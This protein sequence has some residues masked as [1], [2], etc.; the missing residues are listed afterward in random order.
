MLS[1]G[2]T[3]TAVM[4]V[5]DNGN[6]ITVPLSDAP[7]PSTPSTPESDNTVRALYSLDRSEFQM[8]SIMSLLK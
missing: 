1:Y 3:P 7:G 2:L 4:A 8:S 5:T 6:P